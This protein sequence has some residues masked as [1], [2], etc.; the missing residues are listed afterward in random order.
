MRSPSQPDDGSLQEIEN[1]RAGMLDS[2]PP[3]EVV[4]LLV[5]EEGNAVKAV[6]ARASALAS[7]AQLMAD[8]LAA[9]GRLVYVGVGTAGR[10]GA[11]EAAEC[12][13]AFGLPQSLVVSIIAGGPHAL[14][15][16]RSS[17]PV[18]RQQ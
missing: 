9:G 2:L 4:K 8:K 14:V 18:F 1:P 16:I 6:R 11:L 5:E 3:E 7:A 12:V 15:R 10:L 13:P 17:N